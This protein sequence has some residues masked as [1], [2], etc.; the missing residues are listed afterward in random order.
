MA[1]LEV[2][3]FARYAELLGDPA[4]VELTMPSSVS[5]LLDALRQ[6]PGGDVLPSHPLVAINH[7]MASLDTPIRAGDVVALLP[8]LAGG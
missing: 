8:P 6:L 4:A 3:T 5:A 2:R 1:R 7:T